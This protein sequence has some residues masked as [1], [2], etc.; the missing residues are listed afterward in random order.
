MG[1]LGPATARLSTIYLFYRPASYGPFPPPVEPQ[2]VLADVEAAALHPDGKTALVLRGGK[3]WIA[4]LNGGPRKEFWQ[5]V[6]P[7]ETH[8]SFLP[9]G[10]KVGFANGNDLWVL[11][12][13][14]GNLENF[15]PEKHRS[16]ARAGFRIAAACSSPSLRST[17][18]HR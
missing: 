9:D 8:F 13:P 18:R 17:A 7:Y 14:S 2:L 1:R 12:Y 3:L 16:V 4:P 5:G 11:P 15:T 6:S 10:S